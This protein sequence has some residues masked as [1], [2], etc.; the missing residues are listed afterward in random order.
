LD[1]QEKDEKQ[2]EQS[3]RDRRAARLGLQLRANL[4][5]RKSGRGKDVAVEPTELEKSPNEGISD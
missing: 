3:S 2:Q 5:R 1:L 4:K